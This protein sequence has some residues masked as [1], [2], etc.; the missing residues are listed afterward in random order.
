M[1]FL[2]IEYF[3]RLK[4]NHLHVGSISVDILIF[5]PLIRLAPFSFKASISATNIYKREDIG[6]PC[7]IP[8][9]IEHVFEIQPMYFIMKI[10]FVYYI[11]IHLK[12]LYP[13]L[14]CLS[15]LKRKFHSIESKAFSKSKNIRTLSELCSVQYSYTGIISNKA[16]L[17]VR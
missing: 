4:L 8:L 17:N 3:L 2:I 16:S 13:K 7:L 6:H 5:T 12:K 9:D 10:G 11:F 14:N 15:V 1:L